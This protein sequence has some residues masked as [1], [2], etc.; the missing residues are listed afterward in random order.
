MLSQII[1][2]LAKDSGR[3]P[4]TGY[5]ASKPLKNSPSSR[6]D[7]PDGDVE[8]V[9]VG[10]RGN[11][12][13]TQDSA[14]ENAYS[15]SLPWGTIAKQMV[16]FNRPTISMHE[17]KTRAKDGSKEQNTI[18][19]RDAF[20]H[21]RYDGPKPTMRE[22]AGKPSMQDIDVKKIIPNQD[23]VKASR[24][25]HYVDD[26]DAAKTDNRKA[27]TWREKISVG[28]TG[29]GHFVVF[30]GHHRTAAAIVSGQKKVRA[31]VYP[32]ALPTV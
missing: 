8:L 4:I 32:K 20:Y 18:P 6:P 15:A 25:L 9:P 17:F 5:A 21:A 19:V 31:A 1:L 12:P 13:S 11:E 7:D 14:E 26:P 29:D 28:P 22:M 10:V 2:E 16:K 27:G 23:H 24:V 30:D 3:S